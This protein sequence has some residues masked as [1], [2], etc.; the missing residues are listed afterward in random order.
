MEPNLINYDVIVKQAKKD[1]ASSNED[2]PAR[3]KQGALEYAFSIQK[4]HHY[5]CH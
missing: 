4:V 2:S 3:S 5:S 1:C